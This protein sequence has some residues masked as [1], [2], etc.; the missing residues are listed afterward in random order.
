M[1]R[2]ATR[3]IELTTPM[4]DWS[5]GYEEYSEKREA[6]AVEQARQEADKVSAGKEEYLKRKQS[7]ADRRREAARQRKILSEIE[8]LEAELESITEELFGD[9]ATD[10]VRAAELDER[11]SAVEER[12]LELY[13]EQES[14]EE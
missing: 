9:A 5:G 10:Y 2:L 6:R 1:K 7:S 3:V 4:H 8:K 12:L 11:K 13:E 14:F